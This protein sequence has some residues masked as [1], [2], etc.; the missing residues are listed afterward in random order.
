[1]LKQLSISQFVIISALTV[2]FEK[3]LTVLTGETGAGKSI[4]LD[5]LGII[6]GDEADRDAIRQGENEAIIEARFQ[7][8]STH[9]IWKY[10]AGIQDYKSDNKEI[11][12][13]RVFDRTS[14]DDIYINDVPIALTALRQLGTYL[15]EIHGQS[16]NQ[17]FLTPENQLSLLDAFGGYPPIFLEN[18]AQAFVEISRTK[19]ALD[20]ERSFFTIAEREKPE[21]ESFVTAIEKLNLKKDSY[22]EMKAKHAFLTSTK[23][24]CE[25]FQSMQA[26]LIAQSGVELSLM[27]IDRLLDKHKDSS[28]NKL[29]QSIKTALEQTVIAIAEMRELGPNYM[30]T[31]TTEVDGVADQ[32]EKIRQV[33]TEKK[34]VPEELFEKYEAMATRLNRIRNA[35]AK[36]KQLNDA[37]IQASQQYH[38]HARALSLE[39]RKAAKILSA[40]ITAEMPPLK[41]IS[42]QVEIEVGEDANKMTPLGFNVVCFTA[43]MNPGMPF[44]PIAKTASGGELSRLILAVKM[45]LQKVQIASTLVFDEIDSGIGGAA[46][47]AV[48]SR[49]ARLAETAQVIVITHSPQVAS[50]GHQHLHV[51][52]QTDGTAT[53]SVVEK[54]SLDKRTHEVSRMLAGEVLTD[55]SLAAARSL[56][57]EARIAVV[58]RQGEDLGAGVTTHF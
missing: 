55:H 44:S 23:D 39:R 9:S 45:I 12:I 50:R 22:T 48:G 30:G 11:H 43:R 7:P 6:L 21:L 33:A 58:T 46:A 31:D 25:I 10:L 14:K 20:E 38:Q 56:I 57:D 19:E 29:K 49:I 16:A 47:A 18:V 53:K 54:L 24:I 15:T 42:A 28:L 2:D 8:D 41:L 35:P 17:T 27:R 4:L 3:G 32:L 40:S 51:S 26:Q 13:K 1:M 52:K 36:I 37:A 34:I 5:A